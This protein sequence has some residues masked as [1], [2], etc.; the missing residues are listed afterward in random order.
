MPKN[1]LHT[2]VAIVLGTGLFFPAVSGAQS[3]VN[4]IE[5]DRAE[6]GTVDGQTVRKILGNVLLATDDMEMQADSAY[7]Y[8]GQNLLQAFNIQIETERRTIWA[9]TIYHNTQTEFSELRGRVIVQS[10]QNTVFSE[11]MDV[12][13][14]QDLVIFNIPVR[15][16]DNRGTLLA[17]SGLY[18]QAVDSAVFR[19][20]VQLSDSTQYLEADS[21]F[22]NRSDDF[23]E[24]HSRVYAHDFEDDV[25]FAGEYLRADSTGYRLLTDNAWLMQLNEAK[26]DTTHLLAEEIEIQETDTVSYMDAYRDVRIW[27]PKFSA[28]ADTANYR[29]D[30]DQFILRAGPIVWQKRIQL[31]GPVIE[32]WMENDDIRFLSSY[33]RPIA[34]QEDS[35]TGRL[36]QMTGDTLHAYFD[37]G[38]IE[39]IIVFDNSEIIF[40]L[41]DEDDEPDGLIELI[42]TG[43]ST[44]TFL[45]GEF[46]FFKAE[47]N[48][49]GSYLPENPANIDRQLDNFTW[50][51]ERKPEKPPV[52][53]PRLREI[54]EERP[55]ELPPRYVRYIESV[56][57]NNEE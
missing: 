47:Q 33:T 55:F 30:L 27:S 34:V 41:L 23:Y 24:L 52:R 14:P 31:T 49:D 42:S 10:E 17:E 3:Q 39:K 15:F 38:T 18:Y 2:F 28:I 40:H 8:V 36:H 57:N 1:L 26:T 6:G 56:S 12:S 5:A 22:M 21:L 50:D 9:D 48:P 19:G 45:D 43:P 20:N 13:M 46:D 51:P 32:T 25:T 29:D 11:A 7:Q 35:V 37:E 54:P 44:L 53:F 4:I 16:E